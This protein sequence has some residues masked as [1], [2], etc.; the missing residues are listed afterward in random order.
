VDLILHLLRVYV[1]IV[2]FIAVGAGLSYK[3]L[4]PENSIAV[5]S[6][7]VM[8]VTLPLF[9]FAKLA[10]SAPLG[11]INWSLF[12]CLMLTFVTIYLACF[13]YCVLVL[14]QD[15][16]SA[17][18][19]SLFYSFP[20][21]FLM[22]APIMAIVLPHKSFAAITLGTLVLLLLI[23][24]ISYVLLDW[25]NLSKPFSKLYKRLWHYS[26]QSMLLYPLAGIV[27]AQIKIPIPGIF[28]AATMLV[29]GFTLLIAMLCLGIFL[30]QAKFIFNKQIVCQAILKLTLPVLIG[31]G[32]ALA[33]HLDTAATKQILLL[34]A[35][36]SSAIVV[37][38]AHHFTQNSAVINSTVLTTLLFST[39][40]LGV[41]LMIMH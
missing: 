9:I 18:L 22:S 15:K 10:T 12:T 13:A 14:H 8:T 25:N 20:E 33:F 41:L 31:Y 39:V 30:H 34:M 21:S 23:I 4:L 16:K 6:K 37:I 5:L 2:L 29:G 27:V 3:S 19:N 36:P 24:P 32:Y 11:N 28:V 17:T 38:F 7:F 1:P 35:L 40:S 26:R